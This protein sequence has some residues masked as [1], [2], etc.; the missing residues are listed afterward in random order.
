M[1]RVLVVDD[2]LAAADGLRLL[3]GTDGYEATSEHDP[4]KAVARMARERFDA[5][6]TDLEMPHVHGVE[7][8]R[9]ARAAHPRAPVYVVSAYTDSPAGA[10]ALAAGAT[11]IFGKPLDYDAL[12]GELAERLGGS[13]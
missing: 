7:V 1:K 6:V 4:E 2:D 13:A 5:V 3:L 10:E 11:R 8:V 12:A 9:A